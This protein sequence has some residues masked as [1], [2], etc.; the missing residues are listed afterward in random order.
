MRAHLGAISG[1][2]GDGRAIAF[3]SI[4]TNPHFPQRK[5]SRSPNARPAHGLV[6]ILL[7]SMWWSQTGQG[8]AQS[9]V[10][11]CV[12]A[13]I[14]R[15]SSMPA[16]GGEQSL[17]DRIAS[18]AGHSECETALQELGGRDPQIARRQALLGSR[19]V[20]RIRP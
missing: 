4:R 15:R 14:D 13:V 2:G 8:C 20:V 10:A 3:H 7:R 17:L 18:P 1:T 6:S 5:T 19:H 12:E 16:V 9:N 11:I